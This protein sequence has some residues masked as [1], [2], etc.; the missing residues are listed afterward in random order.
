MLHITNLNPAVQPYKEL[1]DDQPLRTGSA[2][3]AFVS[4][5]SDY[6]NGQPA[7][8][9]FG[10]GETL[11]HVLRAPAIAAPYSLAGQL[12]FLMN[13][14]AAVLGEAFLQ[15][16]LRAHG[17]HQGGDHPRTMG[18]R[19]RGR[20]AGAGLPRRTG[21]RALQPR[22]G[23][24]AAHGADGQEFLRLAGPAQQV[25]P[26]RHPPARP[27]PRRGAGQTPRARHHRAVADRPVGA[28]PRQPAHQAEDGRLGR[29]GL[30]LFAAQLR[31]RRRP[32]GLGGARKSALPRL[33]ARHPPLGGHG[34]QP[35]GHRLDLGGRAPRLVPLAPLPAV[36][37]LLLQQRGPLRRRARW[38]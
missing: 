26:A 32:W 27:D 33:A 20:R 17:L 6:F 10:A 13:R 22:Q 9:L 2:Y 1:F 24:D 5:L 4:G 23:L 14:W 16:L 3:E 11:I 8:G 21:V 31:G 29:G 34:P 15:R 28:Q 38:L 18:G 7:S 35:H 30:G 37:R 36:S 12:E 19:I 25:V